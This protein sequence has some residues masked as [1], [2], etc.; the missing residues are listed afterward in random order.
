MRS[1][2]S[3]FAELQE[4]KHKR[5]EEGKDPKEPPMEFKIHAVEIVGGASRIPAVKRI[6]KEVFGMEPSTTLNADEAVA[7]GC[8]L[9]CAILSP[10]FRVARELQIIDYAP[11]Q[12]NCK[13]WHEAEKDGKTY[14]VNPLFSRGSPMPLTRQ[15]S[16]NCRSLP[17][18]FE[19]EYISSSEHVVSIGQFKIDSREKITIDGNKL[20]VKVRLDSDGL[21]Y[22][23]S[24]SIQ[25][26]DKSKNQAGDVQM[27]QDIPKDDPAN[28][29]ESGKAG[30]SQEGEDTNKES[31]DSS[32]PKTVNYDLA[33]EPRWI[34]GKLPD[35]DLAAQTE[36]EAKLIL[37]DKRWKELIDARNELE[38]YVY[39]WRDKMESG[40][41]D[42][43][44][45][46]SDKQDFLG[47]LKQTEQWL[48]EE[49][50]DGSTQKRSIYV[51]KLTSLRDQFSNSIA[52]RVK[53]CET[54]Q[55]YLERL[56]K[57]IQMSQK[58]LESKEDVDEAK[59]A[60]LNETYKDIQKWFENAHNTLSFA[61]TYSD[62]PI[63]T[64]AIDAKI[65]ELEATNRGVMEDMSKR[66]AD[67]QKEEQKKK[68]H[69]E[70]KKNESDKSNSP[71]PQ[72][73]TESSRTEPMD[74]DR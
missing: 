42:C 38:E 70:S 14:T 28:H 11:Y 29:S 34:R 30:E 49:E 69:A 5:Q 71:A 35:M 9:Q 67:K 64:A 53:E 12:I 22:V 15:I 63:T 7:R 21:V 26:E 17:M 51:E 59:M 40:G 19:L 6:V 41:Y 50:D 33:I 60:K 13:Y 2:L 43:F 23:T 46:Q 55:S 74:V 20:K 37:N 16:V 65:N 8:A 66:K 1:L 39:E 31:K 18:I 56:G 4:E 54:R 72:E 36:T 27:S 25:L 47:H 3:R 32:K 48:Y 10:S 58:L 52:F 68:Q 24:A 45:P 61:P 57:S 73:K 44:T 62:P